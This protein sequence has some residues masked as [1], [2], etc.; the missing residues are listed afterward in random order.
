M[1][2]KREHANTHKNNEEHCTTRTLTSNYNGRMVADNTPMI[3]EMIK[4]VDNTSKEKVLAKE[5]VWLVP[6]SDRP[7][8]WEKMG[9]REPTQSAINSSKDLIA[10]K[11]PVIGEPDGNH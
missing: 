8:G 3:N 9:L 1:N 2:H 11:S 5:G 7:K 6:S 10:S 4:D